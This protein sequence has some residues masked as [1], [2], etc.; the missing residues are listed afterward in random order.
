MRVVF[1]MDEA[2]GR[3]ARHLMRLPTQQSFDRRRDIVGTAIQLD[4]RDDVGGVVGQQLES[5][6]TARQHVGGGALVRDVLEDA[7][8]G[9]RRS[10]G[11]KLGRTL[12]DDLACHAVLTMD[13]EI[14]LEGTGACQRLTPRL[15]SRARS[16][17]G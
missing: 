7:E 5:G 8:H 10:I 11:Q 2:V 4:A 16:A 13:A 12:C 1:G 15:S 3:P 9:Q 17:P 14:K 6:V